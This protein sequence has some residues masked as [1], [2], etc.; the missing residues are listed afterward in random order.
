MTDTEKFRDVVRQKGLK[1]K[2]LAAEL[3]ITPFGLQKKIENQ[4]EFKA[5][6]VQKLSALL[7]LADLERAQIF[8]APECD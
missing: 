7:G 4:T 5:S 6:E 1:Y 3:G 8:F 2:F